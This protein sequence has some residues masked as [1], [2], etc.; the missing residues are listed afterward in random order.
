MEQ[1]G[2]MT[3]DQ[4]VEAQRQPRYSWLKFAA[5][6]TILVALNITVIFQL[7]GQTAHARGLTDGRAEKVRRGA[8][9]FL[10]SCSQC[11]GD[12][13]AGTDQVLGLHD[14]EFLSSV[15]DE[16]LR[17]VIAGGSPLT[18]MSLWSREEHRPLTFRQ[19]DDVVAFIRNW[20]KPE[21][22]VGRTW[23]ANGLLADSAAGG[24][25]TFIWICAGC[26]GDD[27]TVPTGMQDI[28]INSPIRLRELTEADIRE[29]I[30]SGGEEM[31]GLANVLSPAEVEGLIVFINTWPQ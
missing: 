14:Q 15:S 16:F 25:E 13:G 3:S 23:T 18:D 22:N 4:V 26:H 30:L 1:Y 21:I 2:N 9:I 7:G 12:D 17:D 6:A 10:S 8:T 5:L 28:V 19:I 31:P 20:E 29:Q 27:G 11:H 24:E